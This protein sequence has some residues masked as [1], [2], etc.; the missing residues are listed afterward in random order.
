MP[1]NHV[2]KQID[3][4]KIQIVFNNKIYQYPPIGVYK[5]ACQLL[6]MIYWLGEEAENDWNKTHELID[7]EPAINKHPAL[8]ESLRV[9]MGSRTLPKFQ[10]Q[11]GHSVKLK[12][13]EERRFEQSGTSRD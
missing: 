2:L 10:N 7:A 9:R 11:L 4:Y 6:E 1:E 3:E 12:C 5:S 13:Y 8:R